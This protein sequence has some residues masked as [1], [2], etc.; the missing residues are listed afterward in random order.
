MGSAKLAANKFK[1]E[2]ALVAVFN[3]TFEFG[4]GVDGGTAAGGSG[5]T[6][7]GCDLVAGTD[8]ETQVIGGGGGGACIDFFGRENLGEVIRP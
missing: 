8:D 2:Y 3:G 5:S 6:G 4:G 7:S 1:L